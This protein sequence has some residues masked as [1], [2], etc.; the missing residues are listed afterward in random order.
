MSSDFSAAAGG[1]ALAAGGG[2]SLSDSQ[3]PPAASMNESVNVRVNG[4]GWARA[5]LPSPPTKE[6]HKRPG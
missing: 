4:D 6:R 2:E 3:L 5:G 1:L